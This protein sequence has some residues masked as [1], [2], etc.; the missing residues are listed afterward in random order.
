MLQQCAVFP[1]TTLGFKFYNHY[2][3]TGT[4]VQNPPQ[5]KSSKLLLNYPAFCLTE[6]I[7]RTYSK[8]GWIFQRKFFGIITEVFYGAGC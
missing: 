3:L 7:F 1:T 6:I 5:K 4:I 8:I 2:K